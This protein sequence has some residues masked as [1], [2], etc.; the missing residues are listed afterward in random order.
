MSKDR[1]EKPQGKEKKNE[2]PSIQ[3]SI[4][5]AMERRTDPTPPP[6]AGR[7]KDDAEG[8]TG[9]VK[10]KLQVEPLEEERETRPIE[11]I[12]RKGGDEAREHK[13]EEEEVVEIVRVVGSDEEQKGEAKEL[14][15]GSLSSP[16]VSSPPSRLLR[17]ID[18]I[19]DKHLGDFS[20]EVQLVL[21]E[22]N[23][24]YS[25]PQSPHS[26]SNTDA[27]ALQ[28]TLPHASISQFSQYVSFYNPCPPV[29]DYV[30]SLHEGIN[31]MLTELDDSW[32][33]HK[34]PAIS[35]T[36]TDAALASKVSAFVS[37]IRAANAK[38]GRD[39]D[40]DDGLCGE[41]TAA[42]VG[43]GEVWQPHA[44]TKQFPDAT[45]CTNPSSPHAT[46]SATTSASGSVYK[47]ANTD[48]LHAPP[49]MSPQPHWKPQQSP[50]L[51]INRTVAH[52]MI[53]TQD[54]SITRTVH[55]TAGVEGGTTGCEASL[56]GFSSVSK[57][58]TESSHPSEPVSSLP[59]VSV[60]GPG[61]APAPPATALSS[62]ISQLQPE[63]F[64]NLMEI[65]KDVKRNSPLFYLHST[66]PEDR[67][68]EEVKVT[69]QAAEFTVNE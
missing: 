26:T 23:I 51:E 28:H 49:D 17:H 37:S 10:L 38:T 59:S 11:E 13:Q 8:K 16:S 55:C 60:P 14:A 2:E 52:S 58:L 21:Q 33:S 41:L 44:V 36:H 63:V 7:E 64:N 61:S 67:V 48:V 20:S 65:I 15:G 18:S 34:Q 30:S 12:Q 1:E 56:A 32:P 9:E 50:T 3:P 69:E 25:F 43:A 68:H 19:V 57:P 22:E 47:P 53:Q 24:H 29:Q 66:E 54:S 27:T 62:L 42:D 40:D 4:P 39:D 5:P 46:L 35:R 45:N 31:S 6:T